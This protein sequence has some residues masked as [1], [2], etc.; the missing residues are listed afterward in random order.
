ME[1]E[2][3]L[4][5]REEMH[6]DASRLSTAFRTGGVK[7]VSQYYSRTRIFRADQMASE[8][9]LI[10]KD[11]QE[12]N[13][14]NEVLLAELEAHQRKLDEGSGQLEAKNNCLDELM[15]SSGQQNTIEH[16]RG[17]RYVPTRC[18]QYTP[19][20]SNRRILTIQQTEAASQPT[21]S[22]TSQSLSAIHEQATSMPFRN[23]LH[24][25]DDNEDDNENTTTYESHF[26]V[27]QATDHDLQPVVTTRKPSDGSFHGVY[28]KVK[29]LERELHFD[30]EDD[31]DK[32]GNGEEFDVESVTSSYVGDVDERNHQKREIEFQPDGYL[33]VEPPV[34]G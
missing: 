20:T 15:S 18:F 26:E 24:N 14:E 28:A 21:S 7:Y 11:L 32:V 25:S 10:R 30:E 27:D 33:T 9:A 13:A 4:A 23:P 34:S 29:A 5:L 16:Q 8:S 6:R 17:N 19:K 31:G 1:I 3:S 2:S 22:S 12:K